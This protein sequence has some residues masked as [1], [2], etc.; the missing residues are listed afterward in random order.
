MH[1]VLGVFFS[2]RLP[3]CNENRVS[4]SKEKVEMEKNEK[5][6]AT[7]QAKAKW[8]KIQAKVTLTMTT[9]D[10]KR[11]TNITTSTKQKEVKSSFH[12]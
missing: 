1:V 12:E 6:I 10:E 4:M 2:R 3:E 11:G 5:E 7:E 9:N 8:N